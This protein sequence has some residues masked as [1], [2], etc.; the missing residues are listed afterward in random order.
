MKTVRSLFIIV[1]AVTGAV[2]TRADEPY[3]TGGLGIVHGYKA[4]FHWPEPFIRPD[5][6]AVEAPYA[7][8]INN[9]WRRQNTLNDS[10]FFENG[11]E[12][13]PTGRI[14]VHSILTEVPLS[15][16]SVFVYRAE[17]PDRTAA[18]IAAVQQFAAQIAPDG[19]ALPVME[20]AVDPPG[21]L[22]LPIDMMMRSYRAT[23]PDPRLPKQ[24]APQVGLGASQ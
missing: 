20:T 15:H 14:K 3:C 5:R 4:V 7:V 16:R 13:S 12:L 1:A 23:A 9:G 11:T 21:S 24:T 17:T 19:P 10:H 6:E 2:Q 8:M 22:A 18:R